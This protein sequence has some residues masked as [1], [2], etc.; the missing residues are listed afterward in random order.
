MRAVIAL[1][2]IATMLSGIAKPA[3][4]MDGDYRG[5]DGLLYCG[6]CHA[7]KESVVDLSDQ[8]DGSEQKHVRICCRCQDAELAAEDD[9]KAR[10]RFAQMMEGYQNKFNISETSYRRCTFAAD[11]SPDSRISV[12]CR[13]YVDRWEKVRAENIGILFYGSV[14]TG[15]SF[16]ACAI[17]NALLER[18]IPAV[19]TNFPRLLNVRQG[20]LDRQTVIDHLQR[21]ELLMLDDLGVERD[22]A[23]AAE[24]VFSIIDAR[25][26]SKLPLIV[27][28]NLTL[29]EMKSPSTM[30]QQRIYD[31]ILEM[32][33]V[34][35][36][37][38]GSSRRIGN[39][40]ARRAAAREILEADNGG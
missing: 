23:Y 12:T 11:D 3:E 33:P 13:R 40:A 7:P 5:P 36:K 1:S 20:A 34:P 35:L 6:K 39:A 31:R 37:M 14:G 18:Q 22:T 16:Y 17:V 10:E 29:E 15:K 21:Y 28:T 2:E 25:A 30:Q 26:R 4:Q 38:T 9:K 32:C 24:Q 8:S 19:A 27:T